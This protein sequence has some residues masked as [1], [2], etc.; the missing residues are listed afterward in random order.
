MVEEE[1]ITVERV[2][3]A[4]T[5]EAGHGRNVVVFVKLRVEMRRTIT[6]SV[7]GEN[8]ALIGA[9]AGADVVVVRRL[10]GNFGDAVGAVWQSA[11]FVE[12]IKAKN[13]MSIRG[14]S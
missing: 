10:V 5:P 2:G 12:K 8:D 7:A 13:K 14:I 6:R 9:V 1:Q 4:E 3:R 11:H